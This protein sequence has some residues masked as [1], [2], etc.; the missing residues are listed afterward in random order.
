MR[1]REIPRRPHMNE[2]YPSSPDAHECGKPG[3]HAS[4]ATANLAQAKQEE[5][6]RETLH[7]MNADQNRAPALTFLR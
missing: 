3:M 6:E 7:C 1:G 4:E 2:T 5:K